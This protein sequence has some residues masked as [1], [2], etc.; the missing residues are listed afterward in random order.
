MKSQHQSQFAHLEPCVSQDTSGALVCM[1]SNC[2][3]GRFKDNNSKCQV[4]ILIN[5]HEI[6]TFTK[7]LFSFSLG[8]EC[9]LE[10]LKSFFPHFSAVIYEEVL[11]SI[12]IY[13]IH[14][15]SKLSLVI[16]CILMTCTW[17]ISFHTSECFK[18]ESFESNENRKRKLCQLCF[19]IIRLKNLMKFLILYFINVNWLMTLFVYN[20]I[21]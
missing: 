18:N 19:G 1:L 4:F 12:Y 2:L 16:S 15:D 11:F 14:V 17:E 8:S 3:N 5:F 21:Q 6:W 9:I 10:G 7:R 13:G 20:Y